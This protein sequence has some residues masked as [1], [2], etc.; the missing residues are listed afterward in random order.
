MTRDS[1]SE[2]YATIDEILDDI[3]KLEG[4][5][6]LL[7][8]QN[9]VLVGDSPLS[10]I[11]FRPGAEE[12]LVGTPVEEGGDD[13]KK[14]PSHRRNSSS[15]AGK[16][17]LRDLRSCRSRFIDMTLEGQVEVAL[18]STGWR[19]SRGGLLCWRASDRRGL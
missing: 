13:D 5:D 2:R 11:K 14:G 17:D 16:E 15:S 9:Q 1:R 10:S 19:R 12:P 18:R 7:D 3:D 8:R 6:N 4:M